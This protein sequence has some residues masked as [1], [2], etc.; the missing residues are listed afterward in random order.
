MT[1][2]NPMLDATEAELLSAVSA[3]ELMALTAQVSA[4]VRLSGSPEELR[5]L[6]LAESQLAAWGF[7]TRLLAHDG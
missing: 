6:R 5:A 2:L 7:R 4:E 3:D 1:A